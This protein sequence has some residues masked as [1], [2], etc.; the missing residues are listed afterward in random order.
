MAKSA[1]NTVA[2]SEY[3]AE[4]DEK[5]AMQINEVLFFFHSEVLHGFVSLTMLRSLVVIIFLVLGFSVP[6][7]ARLAGFCPKTV[8]RKKA[9]FKG[10]QMKELFSRKP[11]SGRKRTCASKQDEIIR[12]LESHDYR[13]IGQIKKMI[14]EKICASISF[15]AVRAFLHNVGYKWLKCGSLP[16]KA[17]PERQRKFYDETE[18]PLMELAKKGEIYLLYADA[19]HFVMG[20]MHLGYIWSRVRRFLSTF[21]GRVR[22]NVL[23]A[24]DFATKEMTTVTNTTYITA[25]QVVELLD[26]IAHKYTEH[27]I[28]L[29]LDNAKYQKCKLVKEHAKALGITLVYLPPYSPNLNFIERFWK[30]VKKELGCAFFDDFEAFCK[31][32]DL[33]CSSTHT[34][35]KAEMDTLIGGKVQLFDGMIQKSGKSMEQHREGD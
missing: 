15:S 1:K 24:L 22:Y 4:Q 29:V 28:F 14:Q 11:G 25:T 9:L 27:L 26:K 35:L 12:E 34:T 3:L 13:S 10:G 17:D 31:N 32:I 19:S 2:G 30:L 8:R 18:K 33:L 5:L 23:G 21:T 6:R 7:V 20:N 16:A